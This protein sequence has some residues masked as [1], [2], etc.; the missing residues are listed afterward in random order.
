VFNKRDKVQH[1]ALGEIITPEKQD[2]YDDVEEFGRYL[3]TSIYGLI[4]GK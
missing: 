4:N 2:K 1:V 3:R